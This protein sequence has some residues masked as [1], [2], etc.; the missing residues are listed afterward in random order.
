MIT[1]SVYRPTAFP[2][3]RRAVEQGSHVVSFV[4]NPLSGVSF[5]QTVHNLKPDN[6]QSKAP[7]VLNGRHAQEPDNVQ[8]KEPNEKQDANKRQSKEPNNGQLKHRK[9]PNNGQSNG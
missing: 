2:S 8:S 6:E 9:E 4:T 5:I 3:W 7:N 1:M